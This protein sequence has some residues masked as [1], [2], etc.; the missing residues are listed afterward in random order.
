MPT[1]RQPVGLLLH[2]GEAHHRLGDL[3]PELH[4]TSGPRVGQE[5]EAPETLRALAA[6]VLL[7][8]PDVVGWDGVVL[9]CSHKGLA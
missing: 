8:A 1:L 7:D 3:A 6:E 5:E 9:G 2:R 4:Q